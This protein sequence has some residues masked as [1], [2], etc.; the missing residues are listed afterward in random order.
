MLV[1]GYRRNLRRRGFVSR[2]RCCCTTSS[3]NLFCSS[4]LFSSLPSTLHLTYVSDFWG[5]RTG[6]L[7]F[8]FSSGGYHGTGFLGGASGPEWDA[9]IL[10]GVDSKYYFKWCT[11]SSGSAWC[12]DTRAG[13]GLSI[14]SYSCSPPSFLMTVVQD[15]ATWPDSGCAVVDDTHDWTINS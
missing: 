14:T 6:T 5:T 12:C 3:F 1:A 7:T 15:P 13:N 10:C 9:D 2:M 11:V 8:N 4:C